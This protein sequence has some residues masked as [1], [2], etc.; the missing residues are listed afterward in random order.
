L[1]KASVVTTIIALY[2]ALTVVLAVPLLKEKLDGLRTLS[3]VLA[4]AAG[5]A[6]SR[7]CHTNSQGEITS[8]G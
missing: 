3:V 2:P 1:G 5:L 6:L 8:G 7:A 4:L